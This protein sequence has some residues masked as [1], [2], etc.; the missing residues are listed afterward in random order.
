MNQ[1]YHPYYKWECY[2]SGMWSKVDKKT[3]IELLKKAIEFTGN[4]KLYG[5][6]M[7]KV[8]D[9]W[10][11]SMENFLTNKSINRKA[12]IGHCAVM[13]AI[14]IPEYITR[15]AWK[16]LTEQQRNLANK[17]AE[18]TILKWEQNRRLKTILNNGNQKHINQESQ[19]KHQLKLNLII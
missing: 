12:Y 7:L 13:Y 15:M 14:F 18:K 6:N 1:I 10:M 9:K 3:E 2:K 17:Q 8:S 5:E 19:I 16:H 4:H 11:Y